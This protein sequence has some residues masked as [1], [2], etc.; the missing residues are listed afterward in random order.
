MFNLA[1]GYQS[2]RPLSASDWGKKGLAGI[3]TLG[4]LLSAWR[5]QRPWLNSRVF[6]VVFGYSIVQFVQS[7]KSKSCSLA[8]A[9]S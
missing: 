2:A 8:T 9:V 1:D 3:S 6:P 5:R 7:R 4:K